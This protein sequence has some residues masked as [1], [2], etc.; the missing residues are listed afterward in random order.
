MPLFQTPPGKGGKPRRE[1]WTYTP[2][3]NGTNWHAYIAG[4][5]LWFDC[6][7][8]GRTKPCLHTVTNGALTCEKCSPFEVPEEVGFQPLYREDTGKPVVVVVHEYSRDQV[9]A[10][11]FHQ[12][13]VVGR[14]KLIGSP[15][16]IHKALH[17]E[18]RYTSSLPHR[19]RP[20]DPTESLVR[21]WGMPE[22]VEWFYKQRGPSDTAVSLPQPPPSAPAVTPP[23]VIDKEVKG[24]LQ[25]L[26]EAEERRKKEEADEELKIGGVMNHLLG[27]A[28]NGK[29]PFKKK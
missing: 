5:C 14:E 15:L 17:H 4:P 7:T 6:H 18:P 2:T 22:L 11:R 25:K 9:D 21:L 3:P 28:T 12:R 1:H 27:K 19:M 24:P 16:W 10:L 29:P 26:A 13:V 8:K 23:P 20:A